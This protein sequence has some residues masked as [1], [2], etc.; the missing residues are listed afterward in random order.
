[1]K[2][3]CFILVLCFLTTISSAQQNFTLNSGGPKQ[4]GY[5]SSVNYEKVR[6]KL[7]I[8]ATING[9]VYRFI[10]D[11]GAPN[12]I[13][14]AVYDEL[15][16]AVLKKLPVKDANNQMDSLTIVSLSEIT[17]GNIVFNDIP[18]LVAKDAFIF[19]C[20]KVDGFIGS[21][22]LRSSIVQFSS[23]DSTMTVTDQPEKLSLDKKH[24]SD[25]LLN[26][27]QSSPFLKTTISGKKKG[28]VQLL[29]DT[30]MEGLYAIALKHYSLLESKNIFEVLAS[31]TGSTTLALHG[32][33]NDTTQYKLKIPEL[34][35][36]GAVFKNVMAQT[37][38]S[39]NSRI[40]AELLKYGITTVDYQN[41]KFYFEPFQST[42]DLQSG[43]FPVTVISKNDKLV[44]GIVWDD[45]LK[46]KIKVNDEVIAIDEIDYTRLSP[47]EM[48]INGKLFEGKTKA[49]LT[50]RSADGTINKV[51][52][53]K[54]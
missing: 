13:T 20:L 18:T 27:A 53:I 29:F 32:T 26:S 35:V 25:L 14:K 48:L 41:K 46:D 3:L 33:G 37:T 36:N 9:K 40:G 39:E 11:T 44:I 1:M 38:P 28:S 50:L 5:F 45:T 12:M 22:M 24:S 16:P 6:E 54:K 2:K 15:K 49:T 10:V 17:L 51:D 43:S 52:V 21:N 4:R 42:L 7:V 34:E 31:S 19:D 30:G 8:K 23:K 47:C